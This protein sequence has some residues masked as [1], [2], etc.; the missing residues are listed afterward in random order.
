MGRSALSAPLRLLA[1]FVVGATV[2]ALAFALAWIAWW[3]STVDGLVEAGALLGG[4]SLIGAALGAGLFALRPIRRWSHLFAVVIAAA[5]ASVDPARRFRA[6]LAVDRFYGTSRTEPWCVPGFDW[7]VVLVTT[8]AARWGTPAAGFVMESPGPAV[9]VRTRG[10][11]APDPPLAPDAALRSELVHRFR[12]LQDDRPP[13]P[14]RVSV[15]VPTLKPE[16]RIWE[17]RA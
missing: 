3:P 11:T 6:A 1:G 17:V 8:V 7:R 5:G 14:G 12:H 9:E 2:T 13:G 16:H 15:G 4:L 10:P